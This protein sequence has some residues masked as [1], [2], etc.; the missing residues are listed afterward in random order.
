M[1]SRQ[2]STRRRRQTP[3]LNF[4]ESWERNAPTIT[5]NPRG[6]RPPQLTFPLHQPPLRIQE[7]SFL[8]PPPA[9]SNNRA[10][11]TR[12]PETSY[13]TLP[14]RRNGSSAVGRPAV[15][16]ASDEISPDFAVYVFPSQTPQSTAKRQDTAANFA[17]CTVAWFAGYVTILSTLPSPLTFAARQSQST[18]L[19]GDDRRRGKLG[20]GW[21]LS[22]SC[23]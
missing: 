21:S 10:Q 7:S 18:A 17:L 20:R 14:Y 9:F 12:Y 2:V 15:D 1:P 4:L 6:H 13:S 3:L 5:R 16:A 19:L 11:Y 22:D 8:P 23:H